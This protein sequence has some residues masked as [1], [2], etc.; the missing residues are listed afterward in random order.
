MPS[1]P[2]EVLMRKLSSAAMGLACLLAIALSQAIAADQAVAGSARA[3][4][5]S[6]AAPSDETARAWN[7]A[8]ATLAPRVEETAPCGSIEGT[9]LPAARVA[10]PLSRAEECA[11]RPKDVFKE[12][13]KC[14]EMVVV[15]AGSFTMG[16]PASEQDRRDNEGPQHVV[17]IARP[18]AL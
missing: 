10:L 9:M 1:G 13:D 12:C 6:E 17:T 4:V 11:L 14:A 7:E 3:T 18:F 15:P 2:N 5:R 8:K 16:S